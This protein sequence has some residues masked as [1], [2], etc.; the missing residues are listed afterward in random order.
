MVLK[1]CSRSH[2]Q[3]VPGALSTAITARSSA[4]DL[5]ASLDIAAAPNP[6]FMVVASDTTNACHAARHA[7]DVDRSCGAAGDVRARLGSR[8]AERQQGLDGSPA[9]VR[10]P[11]LA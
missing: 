6:V 11:P 1:V 8:R 4:I 2:G 5:R 7:N 3:P 9:A 10:R